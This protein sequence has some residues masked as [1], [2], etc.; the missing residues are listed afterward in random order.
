[1]KRI[2]DDVTSRSKAFLQLFSIRANDL[3]DENLIAQLS[4]ELQQR[5]DPDNI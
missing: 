4:P 3:A 1:M 2:F 5:S